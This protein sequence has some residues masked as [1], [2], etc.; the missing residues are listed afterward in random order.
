MYT[1]I[2]YNR[3]ANYHIFEEQRE[4]L[5]PRPHR[6]NLGYQLAH[7]YPHRP[8]PQILSHE[9]LLLGEVPY[10]YKQVPHYHQETLE[11][12]PHFSNNSSCFLSILLLALS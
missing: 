7:C 5:G 2:L 11:G 6:S 10:N 12:K 9:A 4:G 3:L 8:D 1:P